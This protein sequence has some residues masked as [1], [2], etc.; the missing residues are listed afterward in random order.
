MFTLHIKQSL[1]LMS[2]ICVNS[3]GNG[4]NI[5]NFYLFVKDL[6]SSLK[7]PVLM[8]TITNR[9]GSTSRWNDWKCFQASLEISSGVTWKAVSRM[10]ALLACNN[11]PAKW[12]LI[13]TNICVI[14]GTVK[15]GLENYYVSHQ[16]LISEIKS[17][18]A[19]QRKG[20]DFAS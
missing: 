5:N 8:E 18:A 17:T 10:A 20:Q 2:F 6:Y 1:P 9:D 16:W 12:S 13:F 7:I 11:W 19:A 4:F 14:H 15:P 3:F